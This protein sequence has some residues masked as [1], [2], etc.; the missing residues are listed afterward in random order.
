[1]QL[2]RSLGWQPDILHAH[3]WHA[4]PAVYNLSLIHANDNFYRHTKSLLTVHN[5]PY[6]GHGTGPALDRFGLPPVEDSP[7]PAWARHL[8]LPLGLLT[9]D[10][11]NTVSRG[12]AREMLTPE[13]GAGLEEF[14]L[15]RAE[16]IQGILNGLDTDSWN[17]ETDPHLPINYSLASLEK[18]R[19]NKLALLEELDLEIDP[20]RPLLAMI[21]RMDHQKGVDLVPDALRA[22]KSSHWQA[23]ILG[24]GD[25]ALEAAAAELERENPR[26]RA[27]LRYDGA[28]ARR[29]Y[30]GAD[31]M[32]I[33]SRYEP[34]G[35]T[36]MI[37]MR[38]GC[39]PAARATGGL[40]DT[41]GDY[42]AAPRSE[43]TGF[44]F[45]EASSDALADTLQRALEIYRDQRRWKGLQRRGMKQDFSWARSAVKYQELYEELIRDK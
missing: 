35:L 19:E 24:T 3:D 1:M 44:L 10:A 2:A 11:I 16:D 43:S 25:P 12:Y 28:L 14:L 21:N 38:Y 27:V 41:I 39:V 18:R 23:V 17:P 34:C 15:T 45:Q 9:A 40:K 32:I 31:L 37:A 4:S 30:A 20:D 26:V 13:Y 5:L 7:L 33:P 6:L 36:Q 22:L 42:H 8:P 29:M